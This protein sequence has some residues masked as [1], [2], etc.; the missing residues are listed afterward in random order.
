MMESIMRAPSKA[1]IFQWVKI[2][3]R[4]RLATNLELHFTFREVTN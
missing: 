1:H 2:P 4:Q 3:H